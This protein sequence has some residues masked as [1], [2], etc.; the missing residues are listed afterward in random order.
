MTI[1]RLF[2]A[3][4]LPASLKASLTKLDPGVP[5]AHWV[6]PEQMHLTLGFFGNVAKETELNLREKLSA[7]FFRS[8]FCR[9]HTSGLFRRWVLRK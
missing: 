2:V 5:G 8:F 4:D 6:N 7:Q 9:L 1:K 3:I